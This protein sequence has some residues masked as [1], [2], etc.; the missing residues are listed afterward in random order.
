MLATCK[1]ASEMQKKMQQ[2]LRSSGFG[3]FWA[4]LVHV[5]RCSWTTIKHACGDVDSMLCVLSTD[6][7]TYNETAVWFWNRFRAPRRISARHSFRSHRTTR[8]R[9][10][11]DVRPWRATAT[12][13]DEAREEENGDRLSS[14]FVSAK[15]VVSVSFGSRHRWYEWHDAV[16]Q[17]EILISL[18]R[19]DSECAV[20]STDLAEWCRPD[21]VDSRLNIGTNLY[22]ICKWL[23]WDACEW[24]A[25]NCFKVPPHKKKT[26]FQ[27][28]HRIDFLLPRS[29]YGKIR[30]TNH[31]LKGATSPSA[32]PVII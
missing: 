6:E 15:W 11:S 7:H 2:W 9:S 31:M 16:T 23:I 29:A 17:M 24:D 12:E 32:W 22:T 8:R 19:E 4:F 14:N 27:S 5:C 18:Y 10:S 3:I 21:W 13:E 25:V 28:G 30:S 26:L 20:C 1:N